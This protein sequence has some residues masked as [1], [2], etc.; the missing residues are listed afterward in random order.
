MDVQ[1]HST[2][3]RHQIEGCFGSSWR[4][5]TGQ[6]YLCSSK[7]KKRALLWQ[8]LN[9]KWRSGGDCTNEEGKKVL[10]VFLPVV[11]SM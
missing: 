4:L 6:V 7:E 2:A 10:L 8:M 1:V 9:V 11:T 3:E 5:Q